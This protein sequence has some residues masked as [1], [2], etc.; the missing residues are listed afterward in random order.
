[1]SEAVL[2]ATRV[3]WSLLA[4][5][6]GLLVWM[7]ANPVEATPRVALVIGNAEYAHAQAHSNPLKYAMDRQDYS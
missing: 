5:L 4:T 3:A 1:M 2:M 7:L 6:S